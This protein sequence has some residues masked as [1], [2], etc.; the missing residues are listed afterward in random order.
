MRR[1]IL[2]GLL[3]LGAGCR[4][5]PVTNFYQDIRF[6]MSQAEVREVVF[7][8]GG[9]VDEEGTEGE[10]GLVLAIMRGQDM[11]GRQLNPLVTSIFQ[12]DHLKLLTVEYYYLP[13]QERLFVST[14]QCAEFFAEVAGDITAAYGQPSFRSGQPDGKSESV[15]WKWHPAGRYVDAFVKFDKQENRCG[16]IRTTAFDGSEADLRTFLPAR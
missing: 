13:H 15:V 2:A 14:E 12:H 16:I 4:T 3:L 7:E 6:G 5:T 8:H 9:T 10:S 1:V 11:L